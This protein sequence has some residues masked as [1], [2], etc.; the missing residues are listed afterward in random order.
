[1][2]WFFL[3]G[4]VGGAAGVI[5]IEYNWIRRH[6]RKVEKEEFLKEIQDKEGEKAHE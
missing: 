4:M 3:M 5:L 2:I 6:M 1:M